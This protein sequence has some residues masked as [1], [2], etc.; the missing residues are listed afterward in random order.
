MLNWHGDS[1]GAVPCVILLQPP[2]VPKLT[3]AGDTRNFDDYPE[4]DW[5][6]APPLSGKLV[7]PFKDF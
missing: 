7:E 1:N 3:H 5:K 6:S 2:I 4:E